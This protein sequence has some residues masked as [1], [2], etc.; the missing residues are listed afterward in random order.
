MIAIRRAK[1][2]RKC[3]TRRSPQ[4]FDNIKRL[5]DLERVSISSTA[6][7]SWHVGKAKYLCARLATT[8]ALVA[9]TTAHVVAKSTPWS[10]A[11]VAPSTSIVTI[12]QMKPIYFEFTLPETE[13]DLLR[14]SL[15]ACTLSVRISLILTNSGMTY[16]RP[17]VFIDHA[18]AAL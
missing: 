3:T 2:V 5:A 12:T 17:I 18:D 11:S 10:K 7:H 13:I 15:P 14:T 4:H 1:T 9:Y 6:R 16:T 8:N